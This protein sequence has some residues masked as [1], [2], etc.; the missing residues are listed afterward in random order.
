MGNDNSR[1]TKEITA[2]AVM[3]VL[4]IMV[5]PSASAQESS[6]TSLDIS[7]Q[8]YEPFPA[9]IGQY[10]DVWVKVE[11]FRSGQSDDVTIKLVPEYPLSLDS[12]KNAENNI[13]ILS[14]DSASVQEFRLYVD[15]NAK[16]GTASF[17]VYYRGMDNSPWI[18]D[19]FKIK[20][21][22]TT[23]DSKGTIELTETTSTP[24]M[25]SPGDKGTISFK[26]TNTASES[27]INFEGEDYDTNARIQSASLAGTDSI[28][29]TSG[30][31]EAG[32]IGPGNSVTLTFNVEVPED[33]QEGTYYLDLAIIGNSYSYN[34]IWRVPVTIDS[35]SIK[36]IPS[37]SMILTNSEGKVQFD[38]ANLHQ[39]T[40]SSVSVRPVAE[41]VKFSPAEYFI[42]SMKPDELFTIEFTAVVEEERERSSLTLEAEYR[43][44]FND[45]TTSANVGN[46][47]VVEEKTDTSTGSTTIAFVL[48]IVAA[49]GIFIYKKRKQD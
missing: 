35:S 5:M 11:N 46:L 22:S 44:G 1:I 45:H 15:E 41:G 42:G 4:L 25:F 7:V 28:K 6:V 32:I 26:L 36:M 12:E 48:L 18:K 19:T 14:P 9:E 17:D 31:Q 10:V 20:V 13:G 49:A 3:M 43:N 34:N 47:E 16:P 39:N 40:I 37:K 21:G 29:V 38:V 27:T 33:V 23:F 24:D 8:K 2:F 30:V